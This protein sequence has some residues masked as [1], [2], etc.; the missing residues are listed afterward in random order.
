MEINWG[1]VENVDPFTIVVDHKFQRPEKPYLIEKIAANFDPMRFG[2]PICFLRDNAM[3]YCID[4]QQ[5]IA[6][7]KLLVDRQGAPRSVPIVSYGLVGIQKEAEVFVSINEARISLTGLEKHRGKIVALDPAALQIERAVDK[8]GFSIGHNGESP[9]A[10][11]AIGSL[12]YAHGLVGEEG[13]VQIL[14]VIREAWGDDKKAIDGGILRTIA[15]IVDGKAKN[16]GYNRAQLVRALQKT[17]PSKILRRAEE[18]HFEH[19]TSKRASTRN[20]FKALCKV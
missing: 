10:I 11:G 20:A 3:R 13:I 7:Y 17:T 19:G 15:D 18:L 6:A 14:T 16:G 12:G 2:R 1:K 8:A 9:R 5:R 4:G